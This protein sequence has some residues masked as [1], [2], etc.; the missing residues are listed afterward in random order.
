MLVLPLLFGCA[1]TKTDHTTTDHLAELHQDLIAADKKCSH[2]WTNA[3]A[4]VDCY[5]SVEMPVIQRDAPVALQAFEAFSAKRKLL[6]QRFDDENAAYREAANRAN[7]GVAE[8]SAILAA[9]EPRVTDENSALGKEIKSVFLTLPCASKL[10]LDRVKCEFS[11]GRP[12]WERDAPETLAYYDQFRNKR[13]ELAREYDA[14]M[15]RTTAAHSIAVDHLKSGM[16][17]VIDEFK[18]NAQQAVQQQR[19]AEAQSAAEQARRNAET[20]MVIGA[21]AQAFSEGV[22]AVAC[23]K[24]NLAA[25]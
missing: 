14:A 24:G 8:A 1:Q 19:A 9:H 16:K 17:Q 7:L 25:C 10:M 5:D 20:L 22:K 2:A 15:A 6:V 11:I 23:A 3:I 4:Q 21:L 13:L 18:S 12:I